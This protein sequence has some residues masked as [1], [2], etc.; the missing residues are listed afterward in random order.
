[1]G[2]QG[3]A[4][5]GLGRAQILPHVERHPPHHFGKDRIKGS[6]LH[7]EH[8]PNLFRIARANALCSLN[9]GISAVHEIHCGVAEN[10][11]RD[12]VDCQPVPSARQ[13]DSG[14]ELL[15]ILVTFNFSAFSLLCR[16]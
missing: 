2:L 9:Q 5:I 16:H 14:R 6:R 4:C 11:F 1:M 8:S 12:C 7:S 13:N 10:A 15:S 3:D